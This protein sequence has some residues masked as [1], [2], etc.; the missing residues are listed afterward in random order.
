MKPGVFTAKICD[1]GINE[2]K[3]GS[4]Q[5]FTKFESSEGSVYWYGSL[6]S[7]KKIG[8]DGKSYTRLAITKNTLK[9]LGY[10]GEDI[11]GFVESDALK[12]GEEFQ[13]TIESFVTDRGEEMF[14]VK[15]IRSIERPADNASGGGPVKFT[16]EEA[17][18]KLKA[19]GIVS[20]AQ[21][22]EEIP[23]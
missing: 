9:A 11:L 16:K 2:S 8:K 13:L 7:D 4:V 5:L 15:K 3:K 17:A 18:A 10:K 14:T 20:Q 1:W 6:D 22:D 19:I 21:I 23:F 12:M